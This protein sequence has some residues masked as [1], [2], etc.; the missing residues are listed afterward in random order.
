MRSMADF[1]SG[2]VKLSSPIRR[3]PYLLH[4]YV[5]STSSMSRDALLLIGGRY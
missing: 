4:G 5:A 3:Y 1:I 2:S